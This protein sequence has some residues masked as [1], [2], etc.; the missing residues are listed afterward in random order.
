MKTFLLRVV[1]L[2]AL[3]LSLINASLDTR[4]VV[5]EVVKKLGLPRRLTVEFKGDFP[6]NTYVW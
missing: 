1:E 2:Q 6:E 3:H 5:G 4:S